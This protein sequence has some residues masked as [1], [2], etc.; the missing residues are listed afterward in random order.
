MSL[1]RCTIGALRRAYIR[2]RRYGMTVA[3]QCCL[4]FLLVLVCIFSQASHDVVVAAESGSP[5]DPL[6][7]QPAVKAEMGRYSDIE[8]AKAFLGRLTESGY[9]GSIEQ[10]SDSSGQT[11]YKVLVELPAGSLDPGSA[12][13]LSWSLLGQRA[14]NIHAAVT[15]TG[16]FTDNAF[17]TKTNRKSDFS[18]ILSPE[19]WLN[20]PHTEKTVSYVNISP[21]SAGGHLL[22]DLSGERLFGYQASLYYRADIP[23]LTSETSPYGKTPAQRLAAGLSYIGNNISLNLTDQFE[24]SHQEREAGQFIGDTGDRFNANRFNAGVGYD[25]RNRI[26]VSVDYVNFITGNRGITGQ[27]LDRHDWGLTPALRYRLSHKINLL[28]EY[29]YYAV[30]FDSNN[31]LD[32]REHYL[33]GGVEWRLTEKSFGRIKA[34]YVVKNFDHG[35]S[36]KGASIELQTEHRLSARTQLSLSAYRKTNETRVLNTAFAITTGAR[37]ALSHM[38]TSKLSA[39]LR[40]SYLRDRYRGTSASSLTETVVSDNIY[41]TGIE[42]QYSFRRWL[43]ARAEYLFTLKNS[44]DPAFEYRSNTLLLGLTGTF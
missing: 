34:G 1:A 30:S 40:L 29:T 7:A 25:T 23:L 28:A 27:A 10:Q 11:T 22:A 42:V 12:E 5:A 4:A 36:Y 24:L 13:S 18:V 39:A 17:N 16:I 3:P 41:Q 35:D 43:R 26:I 31:T 44:S 38:I 6:P 8:T 14:R 37:L 19:V 21:R 32:S 9:T 20:T 15:L 33:I 2:S